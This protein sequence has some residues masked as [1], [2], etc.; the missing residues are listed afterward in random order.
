LTTSH[1]GRRV[2]RLHI[3]PEQP[4]HRILITAR[5]HACEM[6]TSYVVEGI[7][8]EWNPPDTELAIIPFVDKDGVEDGDQGK[9]R[10]PRDHNRDYDGDSVHV[11]TKAIREWAPKW[12]DGKLLLALDLHCPSIRGPRNEVI[13]QVGHRDPG[14]WAEQQRFAS[15]L[16]DAIKGELPYDPKNDLAFGKE[17]N[18]ASNFTKGLSFAGWAA[19]IPGVKLAWTIEF[20]YANA[21]G[22]EVNADTARAFGRDLARALHAYIL[23]SM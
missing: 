8:D 7:I 17:W 4:K 5:H 21:S 15:F 14:I 19:T 2:E 6:M 18:A 9:N 13:Y 12:A 10:K 1:K 23:A 22:K 3:G 20:P 16:R 11:E